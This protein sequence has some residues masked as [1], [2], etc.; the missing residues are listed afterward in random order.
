MKLPIE[1]YFLLFLGISLV[2][3]SS[4]STEVSEKQTNKQTKWCCLQPNSVHTVQKK[5]KKISFHCTNRPFLSAPGKPDAQWLA[6]DFGLCR[7]PGCDARGGQQR[8]SD[9]DGEG[10][11]GVP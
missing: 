7:R 11:P 6:G 8:R 5:K 10:R 3:L 9:P 4:R 1:I 2:S